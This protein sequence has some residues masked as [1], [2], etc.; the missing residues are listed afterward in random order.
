MRVLQSIE[1]ANSNQPHGLGLK[2]CEIGSILW[3]NV[4]VDRI[5]VYSS[6]YLIHSALSIAS[7]HNNQLGSHPQAS[8]SNSKIL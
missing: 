5:T 3:V 6:K 2:F 4:G 7:N 1:E 8:K